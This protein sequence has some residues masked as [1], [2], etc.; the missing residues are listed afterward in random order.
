MEKATLGLVKNIA[1][2]FSAKARSFDA[3]FYLSHY[4]DLKMFRSRRQALNHY[5]RHGKAEG[6]FPNKKEYLR[7]IDNLPTNLRTGFDV[8]AYKFYNKDLAQKFSTEEEFFRH[9]VRHGHAEGR[10]CQF[11][12]DATFI[13]ALPDNEKWK[14]IFQ[15]SE[16]LAWCGDELDE[17]PASRE[18]A[19]EIFCS[20]GIRK[21]WPINFEYAF[22]VNFVRMNNTL[23]NHREGS[24]ADLYNAWLTEG[25]PAGSAPNER[26]FLNPFLGELPFPESF[27][28][29]TFARNNRMPQATTR[30]QALVSLFN[31]PTAKIFRSVDLM[32]PDA[33]WLL[34]RIGRRSLGL[35]DNNKAAALFERSVSITSTGEVLCLLG[36]ARRGQRAMRS[37]LEAYNA[38]ML[39]DRAPLWSFLHAAKIY[40]DRREFVQAFDVLRKAYP[41]WRQR[42]EFSEK[43]HEIVGLYFEDRSAAAHKLYR[44]IDVSGANR[45]QADVL[46]TSA[47]EEIHSVYIEMDR[48]PA[49]TGGIAEGYVAILANDDLRQCTHYR[50]EQKELQFKEAGIP[51]RR[52]SHNNVTDFIDSLVGARAAVFYRVAATPNVLRAIIHAKSMGLDTYY[53]VDDLIFDSD[54]Y[55]DPFESFEGQITAQTYAGLQFG[56]PLFRYAMSLCSKSI[57][58]TPALAE[59]MQAVTATNS[60]I[61]VRNGLDER[62]L[63]AIRMGVR[64]ILREDGRIRVFY[65]SGTLAHNADFNRLAGQALTDLMQRYP[66]VD[67]VIVGHLRPSDELAA[68]G[69]RIIAYPFIPDVASYWSVLAACDIN[70]AVLEPG[71]VADCKSEIKWLEAAVLQIPSVLSG[72]RTYRE[73]VQDGVDGFIVEDQAEWRDALERLI[74]DPQ[75][76]SSMGAAARI[77][78]LRDYDIEVGARALMSAFSQPTPMLADAV[79]KPLRVLVCNVFY[80]PQSYGGA[81]RVVE[82]N[83]K[84]FVAHYPNTEIGVFCSDEGAAPAGRLSLSQENGVPVYRLSTPQE[85]GM[86][87]RPFNED[88][89]EPFERVLNHFRPDI[90]HFHCI[91]RLT[92]TIVEVALSRKIPYVV[93]LHDAWWISDNQFL[94]DDDG[95]LQ[96]PSRDVLGDGVLARNSLASMTRRQRLTSLLQH[97]EANLSVSASFAQIYEDAGVTRVQAVENGSPGM[98]PITSVPRA[99]G[100]VALGHIGGRSAHKGASLIEAV[101]RRGT[102]ANLHLTMIDGTLAPGQTVNTTWGTTPVTITAPYPQSQIADLYGQLNV[103]LAPSTWPES[104]GLVAREALGSGLWVVASDLGA[105]GQDVEAGRNGFIIDVSTTHGLAEALMQIDAEPEIYRKAASVAFTASRRV[106]DQAADLQMIYHKVFSTHKA[107]KQSELG[108]ALMDEMEKP[109]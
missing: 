90:I 75:L 9:Y 85:A 8:A 36:D 105:V 23:P 71:P 69:Q 68:M 84:D 88:N 82:A 49:A 33:D 25:F 80:A 97:A 62:N 22:D 38:A 79:S 52:F 11:P 60:G 6:R 103:L 54:F 24:D 39:L 58:S 102:Y 109:L 18:E 17:R 81:T 87:W 107:A 92:A 83:V 61:V 35:G 4:E 57:A 14:A 101:L 78:A 31:A 106:E 86:D 104:F 77:K 34:D 72:T 108:P 48:V 44:D 50:I 45:L 98:V 5:L 56:V 53:E 91:Q 21:L 43:L 73:V 20:Q 59:R 99:D 13:E 12:E 29:R 64:P 2:G 16:F 7:Y 37:A 67:F 93:T 26:V 32:G 65:G 55:P 51:V 46:L 94:V 63:P 19:L 70:I 95:L 66:H 15:T 40:A 42:T 10:V 1:I 27:D 100:R 76:R 30:S 74:V 28:W 47:L 3:S 41:F 96:L 89:A